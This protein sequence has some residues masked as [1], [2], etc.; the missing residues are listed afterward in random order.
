MRKTCKDCNTRFEVDIDDLEEGEYVNCPE[1]NLEYTVVTDEN[2]PIK[3]NLMESK[4]L[5]LEE[6]DE[7]FDEG[8]DYDSD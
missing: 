1:C 2:D 3:L 4:T 8:E 7:Y 5:A 6:D